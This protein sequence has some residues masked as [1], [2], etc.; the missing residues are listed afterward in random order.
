MAF[1]TGAPPLATH[2]IHAQAET[3]AQHTKGSQD[4][5]P[6]KSKSPRLHPRRATSVAKKAVRTASPYRVRPGDNLTAIA[7]RQHVSLA[8]LIKANGISNPNRVLSGSV[9]RIPHTAAPHRAAP[10][11]KPV[12]HQ[13]AKKS[14]HKSPKKSGAQRKAAARSSSARSALSKRAVP[15][16][17][18]TKAMIEK[19]ARRYGV[20]PQLALGISWQE[21]GWNQRVVSG[22]NAIGVMQVLPQSGEWASSMVGHDLD[23]MDT[24]DNITAGVVI[25]RYLTSNAT[26]LDQA[27]GGYYQ[28]LAGVKQHGPYEETKQYVRN[29]RALMER[30]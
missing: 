30:L 15:S 12:A 16:R 19:T 21:S 1:T 9:L 28:G 2:A 24:Q 25:L 18:Q 11:K 10:K 23:L 29:V 13:P 5:A 26:N 6:R 20:N 3:H 4:A 7:A 22:V 14:S 8:A 27:I 17:T